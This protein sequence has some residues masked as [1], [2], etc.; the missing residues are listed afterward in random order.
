MPYICPMCKTVNDDNAKYCKNCGKW[1]LDTIN[2]AISKKSFLQRIPGFRSG[3]WWKKVIA[4][5]FY[6]IILLFII[7]LM[8]PTNSAPT[9]NSKTTVTQKTP[10]AKPEATWHDVITF[11]G[12]SI[13]NTQTFHISSNDW[14]ISWATTPGE[15]GD[16]NFAVTVFTENGNLVDMVANIIGKGSDISYMKGSGDYYLK[17]ISGQPYKIKIQEFK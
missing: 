16:S 12:N 15:Y 10:E 14:A 6:G 3:K 4:S 11:E 9:H 2:P 13:K 17:I 8:I 7:G 1:L 5:I